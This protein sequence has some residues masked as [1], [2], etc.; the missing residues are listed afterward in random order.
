MVDLVQQYDPEAEASNFDQIPDGEYDAQVIESDRLP[1]S[2]DKDLG[3]CLSL[4][5]QVTS[6]E[7]EKRLFWQ[8]LNLWWNGP[9]KTPGKVVQ[10]ANQQFAAVR[11]AT[12]KKIV[13]ASEEL[14]FIPCRVTLGRQKTDPQYQEVKSVKAAGGNVRQIGSAAP[15]AA[16]NSAPVQQQAAAAGGGR[17]PWPRRA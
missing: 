8:R 9:E 10:I 6:G 7:F 1:I 2:N 17:A 13:N 12:G 15:R 14:H 4:C 11:E 5:W 3:E 16:N